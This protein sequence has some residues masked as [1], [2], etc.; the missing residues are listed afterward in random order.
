M[1]CTTSFDTSLAWYTLW[2]VQG[3]AMNTIW[4]PT[5][6]KQNASTFLMFGQFKLIKDRQWTH[7]NRESGESSGHG[8]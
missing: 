5:D 8:T 1:H 6:C 7:L 3:Q 4:I 2:E